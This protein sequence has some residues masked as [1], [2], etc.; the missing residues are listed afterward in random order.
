MLNRIYNPRTALGI[1]L[2]LALAAF[3]P[4]IESDFVN[5]DDPLYVTE[6]T[7]VQAGLTYAGLRWAFRATVGG[8][9][10]PLTLLSHMLDWQ[11]FG[12]HAGW[13]HLT[14]LLL[15]IANTIL[16]FLI[17]ERMT[18]AS[19]KSV[20]V[21]ALFALHPLHVESVVWISERKDVLST[22]FGLLAVWAYI[23]YVE[24]EGAAPKLKGR[25]YTLAILLFAFALMSK[26]MLVTL[27]FV[28]LLLDFWP[29][30]R[31]QC[32][33]FSDGYG[34]REGAGAGSSGLS[35]VKR[36]LRFLVYEK[37]PFFALAAADAALALITQRQA[38]AV[39]SIHSIPT[40]LRMANAV[41]AYGRYLL[42]TFWP[43]DLAV[44]YPYPKVLPIWPVL[45]M[46][47]FLTCVTVIAF[48]L[49]RG[50]PYLAVGWL[51]FMGMLVPVIG[52][53]QVGFQ[54][55]AD[56]YTYLPLVGIFIILAW[57]GSD[58]L[59]RWRHSRRASAVA[60]ALVVAACSAITA[61]Q[62]LYW[63]N[64]Q[65]LF[66]HT[67]AVTS[68]N[69]IAENK[70]ALVLA[71]SGKYDE[72]TAHFR[73]AARLEPHD[74]KA[75]ATLASI[76]AAQGKLDEAIA[77]YRTALEAGLDNAELHFDWGK[78]LFAMGRFDEAVEELNAALSRNPDLSQ[79]RVRLATALQKSGRLA[80][81]KVQW[82]RLLQRET[83]N[84]Y[85]HAELGLIL[86]AE[87]QFAS[88]LEHLNTGVSLRPADP[89]FHLQLGNVL[90]EAR[91]PEAAQKEFSMALPSRPDLA[92]AL[93][94]HARALAA[95]PTR[96]GPESWPNRTIRDPI[97]P[98]ARFARAVLLNDRG[99]LAEASEQLSALIQQRTNDWQA[100][101]LLGLVLARLGRP[102][103]AVRYF[104]DA[105]RI[106][107]SNAVVHSHFALAL[108]QSGRTKEA[109]PQYQEVLRLSPDVP[110]A[111]NNLAWILATNPDPEVR[112]G[113]EAVH[114][115]ERA[116]QLTHDKV[117]AMIST[118]GAAYA[119]A[120]R[121][122][123][124]IAAARKAEALATA[125]GD[126]ELAEKSQKLAELFRSRQA[127]REQQ[128]PVPS[129]PAAP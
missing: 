76:L 45:L 63:K 60:A 2:L 124:A 70:L 75:Q 100:H 104:S 95:E 125:A 119:E 29:L 89:E 58:L 83:N 18:G 71:E 26:S 68:N 16:L 57:G 28:L 93:G 7:Q 21:S 48:R 88:A 109:V 82:T 3:G 25:H 12:Q 6:N 9:W 105:A 27:P 61:R 54:S 97:L 19:W 39:I 101:D 74:G 56:R 96:V 44:L 14:S 123:D 40:G 127:F 120:V 122:E 99:E 107:P 80:D 46:G 108:V 31:L 1:C 53:V 128:Q 55:M 78:A 35:R 42:K 117:P 73:E 50:A 113:A 33:G 116:C 23:R 106:D 38:G 49:R 67:L 111:L 112:N 103:E 92:A 22:F 129:A 47:V 59:L 24:A 87:G 32:L 15:H 79:A 114:L 66:E 65:T 69:S 20:F 11:L 94:E 41:V 13:H 10:H 64:S 4:V 85:A 5:Y 81:A 126:Q 121:F 77:Q 110:D 84:A 86:A 102:K 72:A 34:F 36:S 43:V 98:S 8:N 62:T 51:W 17:L 90:A 91:K 115:A 118:L 52:L 30:G 37:A